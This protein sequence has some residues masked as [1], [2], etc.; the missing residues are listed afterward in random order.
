MLSRSAPGGTEGRVLVMSEPW[1]A[2]TF[3]NETVRHELVQALDT[4]ACSSQGRSPGAGR[5]LGSAER[6]RLPVAVVAG[7][8][9]VAMRGTPIQT[10]NLSVFAH[11]WGGW[12]GVVK[13][14]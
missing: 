9:R 2:F 7:V 1:Q 10:R 4:H 5:V 3:R 11:Y 6:E 8:V 14:G 12:A 13:N